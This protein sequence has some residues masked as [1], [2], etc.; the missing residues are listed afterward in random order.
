MLTV[1]KIVL[2]RL[3]V[4]RDVPRVAVAALVGAGLRNRGLERV[5]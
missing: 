2:R 1:A 4:V 5:A 3:E